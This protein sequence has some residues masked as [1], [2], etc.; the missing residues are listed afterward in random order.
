MYF[1]RVGV[2][3]LWLGQMVGC[4]PCLAAVIWFSAAGEHAITC[5]FMML[6]PPFSHAF[7][8]STTNNNMTCNLTH[9]V[10]KAR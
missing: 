3:F 4:C 7:I 8:V 6:L 5:F 9:L 10:C 1:Q 2:D